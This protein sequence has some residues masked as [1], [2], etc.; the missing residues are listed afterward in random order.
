[1]AIF[2]TNPSFLKQLELLDVSGGCTLAS[3][4]YLSHPNEIAA[5]QT[6]YRTAR[7]SAQARFWCS[8]PQLARRRKSL[9]QHLMEPY[10]RA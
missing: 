4:I 10:F 8:T 7:T 3:P 2:D 1:M 9:P 6:C 5:I